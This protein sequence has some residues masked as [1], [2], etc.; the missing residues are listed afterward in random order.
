MGNPGGGYISVV[1]VKACRWARARV[2]LKVTSKP[3]WI[4]SQFSTSDWSQREVSAGER[5][6]WG[7]K[8]KVGVRDQPE[9]EKGQ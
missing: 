6:G 4:R 3:D 5:G 7:R 9:V 2:P 1:E 8:G